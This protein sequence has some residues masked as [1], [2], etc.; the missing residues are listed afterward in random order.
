LKRRHV[1]KEGDFSLRHMHNSDEV[2]DEES[3]AS[4]KFH[5][6]SATTDTIKALL[7]NESYISM[8]FAWT[9]DSSCLIPFCLICGTRLTN[10]A[11]GPTKLK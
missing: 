4:D 10:S 11:M 9:G 2:T 5:C 6:T 3:Q 1:I 7:Y 8:G